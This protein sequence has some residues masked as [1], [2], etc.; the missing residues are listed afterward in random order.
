[1]TKFAICFYGHIRTW[2]KTKESFINNILESVYP[3]IPDIFIHTYDISNVNSTL[4]YSK[5]EIA[6]MMIFTLKNGIVINPKVIVVDNNTLYA[7]IVTRESE[8]ILDTNDP[9]GTLRTFS[10]LKKIY[11]S[12]QKMKE[13]EDE[14]VIKYDII[15]I[16]RFDVLYQDPIILS[17][18]NNENTI[19][20]HYT[21]APDPCDEVAI[22]LPKGIDIYVSRYKEIFKV[23]KEHT[24][25]GAVS[26]C[27]SHLLLRY[28]CV[29]F[30]IGDWGWTTFRI[31]KILRDADSI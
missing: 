16:T 30:G 4:F 14:N 6:Q 25:I 28:C 8:S 17:E 26:T 2:D 19:Y 18:I 21:G 23:Q 3:V 9:N 7:N 13:Y 27:C 20:L 24:F 11:L 12:Y 22:G 1:M 29:K 15:M 31:I 10:M 5:E